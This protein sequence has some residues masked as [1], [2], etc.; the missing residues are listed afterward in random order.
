M[1]KAAV[2]HMRAKGVREGAIV[3]VASN[4]G[5]AG[6][7]EFGAYATSKAAVVGLTKSLALELAASGIRCNAVLPAYTDTPL[8]VGTEE[9]R[10]RW[11]AS[12]PI[13]RAGQPHEI[14]AVIL[15]LCTPASSFMTGSAV[16]V[17]GGADI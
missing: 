3:N 6:S 14:A 16:D 7:A 17:T 9:D 10:A 1:C 13:G 8:I 15:F 4:L 12:L 11:A 5:K 2:R